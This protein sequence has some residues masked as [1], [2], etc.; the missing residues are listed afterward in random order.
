MAEDLQE[1]G[2]LLDVVEVDR[3]SRVPLYYQVAIAL[4]EAIEGG[5]LAP[6]LRLENEIQL[7]DGL[8]LSRPTMRRA[9]EHLVEQGLIVRRRGIGTT[10]IQPRV[11]RP[12]QLTSLYDELEAAGLHPTTTV[13]SLGIAPAP[14]AAAG[15]LGVAV[16]TPVYTIVRLRRADRNP[17]AHMVNYLPT[18]LPSLPPD[19]LTVQALQSTGLYHLLRSSG[20]HLHAAD[21][22]IGARR[23]TPGEAR[24]LQERR[25]AAVLDLERTTYDDEGRV[26]EYALHL[27]AAS[28]YR[29]GL[30]L[31]TG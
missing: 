21:E 27:Y 13:L 30:S 22:S 17:L 8:G 3:T 12:P 25:G 6:G 9:M 1:S 29:F 5:R 4:Q 10:V 16:G 2:H 7:A 14:P 15:A 31:L 18:T 11:R 19:V 28:R 24:L 23:A 26:T 20:V